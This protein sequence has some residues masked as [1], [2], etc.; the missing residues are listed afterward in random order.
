MIALRHAGLAVRDLVLYV[1]HTG[2]WWFPLLIVLLAV[3][4]TVVTAAKVV[5]PTVVYTLF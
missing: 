4:A 1:V 5:V 3:T 2:K